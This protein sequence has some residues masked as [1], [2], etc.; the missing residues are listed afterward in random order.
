MPEP[1][2]FSLSQPLSH[3]NSCRTTTSTGILLPFL[4]H[5]ACEFIP[6]DHTL[7]GMFIVVVSKTLSF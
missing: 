6:N 4:L 1:M 3:H 7:V 5:I 2:N